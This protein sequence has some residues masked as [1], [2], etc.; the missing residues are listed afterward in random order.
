V[1]V[2]THDKIEQK[3][4]E[5]Y[6]Q[7]DLADDVIDDKMQTYIAK[8]I[9]DRNH[10]AEFTAIMAIAVSIVAILGAVIIGVIVARSIRSPLKEL[11]DAA[12]ELSKGNLAYRI[13]S[14]R[15]DEIGDL[16]HAFDLMSAE[17]QTSSQRLEGDLCHRRQSENRL[18]Q[19]LEQLEQSNQT[20]AEQK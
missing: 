17:V 20:G 5:M 19:K 10:T 18:K 14:K 2:V 15:C 6:E 13:D 9:A 4:A 12:D 1:L 8:R 3:F 7:V 16:A 11:A